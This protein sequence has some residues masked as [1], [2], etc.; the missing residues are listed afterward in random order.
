MKGMTVKQLVAMYDAGLYP[1]PAVKVEEVKE[2]VVTVE[3]TI[4]ELPQQS[5][6]II[7]LFPEKSEAEL[8]DAT[9]ELRELFSTLHQPEPVEQG[10]IVDATDDEVVAVTLASKAV[11]LKRFATIAIH[12]PKMS[13]YD[14]V[15][16]PVGEMRKAVDPEDKIF[17]IIIS[18]RHGNVV[19]RSEIAA[20]GIYQTYVSEA[21]EVMKKLADIYKDCFMLNAEELERVFENSVQYANVIKK[22]NR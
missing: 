2:V 11:F 15:S 8:D 13:F 1:E 9:R 3:P 10:E 22:A 18:T 5:A 6:E 12:V 21:P 19:V 14:S 20:H 4:V 7:Q 17:D 16:I